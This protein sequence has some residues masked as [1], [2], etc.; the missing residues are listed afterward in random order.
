MRS[1]G[2]EL[3]RNPGKK[4]KGEKEHTGEGSNEGG[5]RWAGA[6]QIILQASGTFL[7]YS[8]FRTST[9]GFS[10]TN[11]QHTNTTVSPCSIYRQS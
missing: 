6:A 3:K 8:V 1:L 9:I 10:F 4:E 7:F 11:P 5:E 2:Q